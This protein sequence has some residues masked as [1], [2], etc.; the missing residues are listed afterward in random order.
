MMM[1]YQVEN[2]LFEICSGTADRVNL[3]LSY[4]LRQRESQFRGTHCTG[5]RNQH[6]PALIQVSLV[7]L[8]GIFKGRRVK[9]TIVTGDKFGDG[10]H[11]K[12][13]QIEDSK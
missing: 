6:F 1:G 2:I 7:T 5:H 9:V 8:S 4:H 13:Q 10:A 11:W 12:K 3:I